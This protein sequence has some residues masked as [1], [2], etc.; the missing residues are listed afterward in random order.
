LFAYHAKWL[1][2]LSVTDETLAQALF[3]ENDS[4]EQQQIAVN[5]GI[6][7]VLNND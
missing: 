1:P 3:I 4:R 6:C 7:N 5:N 2:S